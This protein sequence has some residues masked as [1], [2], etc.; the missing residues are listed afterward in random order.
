MCKSQNENGSLELHSQG[1]NADED[2]LSFQLFLKIK[3][4]ENAQKSW[5]YFFVWESWEPVWDWFFFT[6][7]PLHNKSL[8]LWRKDADMNP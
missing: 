8:K 3:Q 4:D 2:N 7:V 5:K 6:F 1:F